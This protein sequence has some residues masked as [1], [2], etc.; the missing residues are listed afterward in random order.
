MN[1]Q[2]NKKIAAKPATSLA[3]PKIISKAPGKKTPE[4]KTRPSPYGKLKYSKKD[5]NGPVRICIYGGMGSGKTTLA[6]DFPKP[7]LINFDKGERSVPV[8]GVP[9]IDFDKYAYGENNEEIAP[10][11]YERLQV[12]LQDA[13][14]KNDYF[15]ESGPLEGIE[16]IIIDDLTT[17]AK[18]FMYEILTF[19]KQL[20]RTNILI[21]PDWD[22]YYAVDTMLTK[23]AELLKTVS[24]TYNVVVICNEKLDVDEKTKKALGGPDVLGGFRNRLGHY[25][26]YLWHMTTDT[27]NGKEVYVT[28]LGPHYP[29]RAKSRLPGY[30]TRQIENLTYA[31]IAQI[32]KEVQQGT[33][34]KQKS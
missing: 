18:Y 29:Y 32:F 2:A 21:K 19:D 12:I 11:N 17:V 8:E 33:L 31:K 4:K 22:H 13:I 14:S 26:D 25:F 7:L 6:M 24:Q 23:I 27:K 10:E 1:E 9:I 3:K 15:A 5:F 20:K 28:Y 16:T 30:T 34:N